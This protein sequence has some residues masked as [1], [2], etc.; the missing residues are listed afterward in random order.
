[1]VERPATLLFRR[2][3]PIGEPDT[4]EAAAEPHFW[5]LHG[6]AG[7]GRAL[8]SLA[9]LGLAFDD[10]VQVIHGPAVSI[11]ALTRLYVGRCPHVILGSHLINTP[12]DALRPAW[13]AAVARHLAP[14]GEALIEHHPVDWAESAAHEPVTPHGTPGMVEVRRDPPFVHAVSVYD[15]GGH[16]ARQP[17]TARVL[18]DEEL[19]N[20][21]A[22][23]GFQAPRRISPTWLA[24]RLATER[25]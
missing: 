22:R 17:F 5:L 13:L 3:R 20:E 10:V 21:L 14:G 6:A 1:M 18:R 25:R 8:V 24:T 9:A 12:D 23:A 15:A 7:A 4:L 19:D 16:E 2:R 11:D